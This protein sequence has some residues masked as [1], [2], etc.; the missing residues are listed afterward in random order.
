[1]QDL[2][3]PQHCPRGV[4]LSQLYELQ[5]DLQRAGQ[6]SRQCPG[7]LSAQ[8][9][10]K[11]RGSTTCSYRS[12]VLLRGSLSCATAGRTWSQRPL[13]MSEMKP[14]VLSTVFSETW[15]SFCSKA[16]YVVSCMTC[17]SGSQQGWK[18]KAP[19]APHTTSSGSSPCK[20]AV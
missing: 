10:V 7:I 16:I 15:H 20:I 6:C 2:R 11:G 3:L 13:L 4:N 14:S 1:M 5:H 12:S 9:Q 19:E 18:M 8:K 17:G